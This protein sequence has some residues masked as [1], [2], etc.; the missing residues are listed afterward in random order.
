[1]SLR[2]LPLLSCALILA[3]CQQG[4][5]QDSG[6]ETP[7]AD[8]R[9][10]QA[11]GGEIRLRV[12]GLEITGAEGTNLIFDSPRDT[13]ERELAQVL[14]PIVDRSRNAEC[15]AGRL[16][17]TRFPGGLTVNFEG[18]RLSGWFLSDADDVTGRIRTA[19][20]VSLGT[21]ETALD[22]AYTVEE[23]D[24]TLGDEFTTEQGISGFLT[25]SKGTRKVEALYSGTTCF[26]R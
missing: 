10:A 24:S 19:E 17:S 2:I 15:G 26:V 14:G 20:G 16:G 1:M 18:D 21:A 7:V 13:V 6:A 8:E 11:S 12:D 22:A 5:E 9:A 3:S 25:G 23:L 4:E